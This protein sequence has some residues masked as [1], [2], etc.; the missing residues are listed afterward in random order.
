MKINVLI[1]RVISPQISRKS[2]L[3]KLSLKN[4]YVKFSIAMSQTENLTDTEGYL[5]NK[6]RTFENSFQENN[7]HVQNFSGKILRKTI[8][9]RWKLGKVLKSNRILIISLLNKHIKWN[10]ILTTDMIGIMTINNNC[11]II[12]LLRRTNQTSKTHVRT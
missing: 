8:W 9:Q 12:V 11:Q 7:V 6:L 5:K 10:K 1:R 3:I 4:Y 2:K